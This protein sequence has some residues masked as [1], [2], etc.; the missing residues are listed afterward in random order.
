MV[1][2]EQSCHQILPCCLQSGSGARQIVSA[3]SSSVH[4]ELCIYLHHHLHSEDRHT[5]WQGINHDLLSIIIIIH[6][7]QVVT[8]LCEQEREREESYLLGILQSRG[9][10]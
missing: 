1:A 3:D 8:F 6:I 5:G 7:D 9:Y 2:D 4:E 10:G